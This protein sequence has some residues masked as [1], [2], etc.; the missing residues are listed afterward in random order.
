MSTSFI[1][2]LTIDKSFLN[3]KIMR[4]INISTTTTDFIEKDLLI[5]SLIFSFK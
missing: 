4:D 5:V 2:I 3:S 1:P